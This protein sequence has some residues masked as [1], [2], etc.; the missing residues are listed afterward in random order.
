MTL[1]HGD[2]T[3]HTESNI[4][5]LFRALLRVSQ[6]VHCCG[7]AARVRRSNSAAMPVT[8]AV[9]HHFSQLCA[10]EAE[11]ERIF[12][13][14]GRSFGPDLANIAVDFYPPVALVTLFAHHTDTLVAEVVA[15]LQAQARVE[16]VVVQLRHLPRSPSEVAYGELPEKGTHV[17]V[18]NGVKY[19]VALGRAQNSGLFLDMAEGRRW[20]KA[21]AKHQRVLNL[22]SFTCSLS[23]AALAGG[24]SHVV[25]VDMAKGALA[26]GRASHRLNGL[27][28]NAEFL[29]Y[30]ILKSFNNIKKRGPYDIVVI[31]PPTHQKGSF[32]AARDYAKVARHVM[33][34]L[35]HGEG[36]G[37][38]GVERRS[39]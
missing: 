2:S 31:D 10:G 14:R 13:G 19:A 12:H 18:E 9:E 16:A 7:A 34:L 20:L 33:E 8:S 4:S 30:N 5:M 37:A 23:V 17:V 15:S 39:L 1:V 22:F 35:G 28:R 32:V 21:N 29:S 11:V 26:T 38:A 25:N 36:G 3:C 6:P 27:D 24:A